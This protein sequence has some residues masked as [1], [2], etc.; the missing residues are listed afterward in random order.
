MESV[1]SMLVP[2]LSIDYMSGILLLYVLLTLACVVWFVFERKT[3]RYERT[4]KYMEQR[5]R[6]S[7]SV[8]SFYM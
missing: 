4:Q 8:Y 2:L 6:R 5:A 7:M 3:N 1:E